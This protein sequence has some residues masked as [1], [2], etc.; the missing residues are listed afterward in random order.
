[1]LLTLGRWTLRILRYT[2]TALGTV[3]TVIG[4]MIAVPLK[5]PAPL[6]S[7]IAGAQSLD[8]S[9]LPEVSFF[10]ARD[11]TA[12][13][14]RKYE[15]STPKSARVAVL[16]HGS[17][18]N[19]ANM[20]A[21]GRALAAAGVP[22]LA[23]D[24]RG[25]GR[26]GTRGDIGYI[27]QLRDDL[28]DAVAHFRKAWPEAHFTLV[29]HSSGGGFALGFAA[30]PRAGLFERYVLLAPYLGPFAPTTRQNRGSAHWAEPDI[31]RILGITLLRRAGLACCESLPVLAF[32]LPPQAIANAT[33]RYSYRLMLDFGPP[34][35]GE[36][37]KAQRPILV[38]A[39]E[40]DELMAAQRY[41][42]AIKAAYA[43]ARI[44]LVPGVDHMG[45]L[46]EPPALQAIVKLVSGEGAL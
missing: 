30:S 42:T 34:L 16:V 6:T 7:I 18:G 41:E 33:T 38:I 9:D 8:R 10:Q 40:K 36:Q 35:S 22:V 13:A 17:A 12:L 44:V 4:G 14:Y 1:M 45:I 32:A 37:P 23:L 11:G 21:V 25:H 3:T 20:H 5:Q 24:M 46:R 29:G 43:D 15:P 27:G 26:S 2:L 19:S 28:A 31:P 39:G